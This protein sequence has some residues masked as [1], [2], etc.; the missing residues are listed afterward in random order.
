MSKRAHS[1]TRFRIVALI[2]LTLPIAAIA[3][4]LGIKQPFSEE[5]IAYPARLSPQ[6]AVGIALEYVKK[7]HGWTGF[8]DHADRH[9]S[10]WYVLVKRG[11]KPSDKDDRGVV[12]DDGTGKAWED[13]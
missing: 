8:A 13:R 2:A 3:V 1:S 5:A 10:T 4:V 6:E 7:K 11:P 12:I 9:F